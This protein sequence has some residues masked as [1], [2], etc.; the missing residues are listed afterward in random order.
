MRSQIFFRVLVRSLAV[1][2]FCFTVTIAILTAYGYRYDLSGQKLQPTGIIRISG[3]Y[4]KLSILLDGTLLAKSLPADIS[5]V[6]Q[7]FHRLE[8]IKEG[9]LPWIADISVSDGMISNVPSIILVPSN[10]QERV[11]DIIS[12]KTLFSQP[13][14]LISASKEYLIVS[15]KSGSF[16]LVDIAKKKRH[17]LSLPK[18]LEA[19]T[20]FLEEARGYG[21][22]GS[23]LK[24]LSIDIPARR[25]SLSGEQPFSYDRDDLQFLEFSSDFQEFLY[26]RNGEILSMYPK[27]PQ[28]R[29]LFTRFVEPIYG[30]SWMSDREHFIVHVGEK[31][32]F[33][34]ASFRNCYLLASM[35]PEDDFSVSRDGVY[36][37]EHAGKNLRFLPLISGEHTFLSY[38][39]SEQVSL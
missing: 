24:T 30:V 20:L 29:R 33:C 17:F 38:I 3:T 9:Y 19:I 32:Q 10:L 34:D 35:K 1:A 31:L 36:I 18:N 11:Q 39:F 12:L 8:V 26:V 27:N 16:W 28:S 37:F 25:I 23:T 13:I 21:F 15:T 14:R 5:G 22:Q 7:G 6:S 4:P 2:L